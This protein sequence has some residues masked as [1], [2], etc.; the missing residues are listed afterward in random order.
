MLEPPKVVTW[1]VKGSNFLE[2]EMWRIRDKISYADSNWRENVASAT[3]KRGIVGAKYYPPLRWWK[4]SKSRLGR[5]CAVAQRDWHN[6]IGTVGQ[7]SGLAALQCKSQLQPGSDS[8]PRS[9][10]CRRV[11]QKKKKR[12]KKQVVDMVVQLGLSKYTIIYWILRW[13]FW[14]F[15]IYIFCCCSLDPT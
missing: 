2:K 9:S 13:K 12:E 5:S 14:D 10:T 4:C 7:E 1:I 3:I 11:S 15:R 8:W 6:G